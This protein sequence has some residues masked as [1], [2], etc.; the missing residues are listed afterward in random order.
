MSNRETL[1]IIELFRGQT[2]LGLLE[3]ALHDLD[4]EEW[5]RTGEIVGQLPISSESLRKHI[6]PLRSLEVF[7]VRDPD[8]NIPHWKVADS[9]V[10]RLLDEYHESEHP[11]LLE[12]LNNVPTRKLVEFFLTRANPEQ[13]YSRNK[14]QQTTE[15]G[16]HGIKDNI[17]RLA[18]AG[19]VETVE[20]KRSMEYRL[21]PNE[22]IVRFLQ[23]L[24]EALYQAYQR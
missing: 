18:E 13:S 19:I 7:T 4:R 10:I 11:S 12:L 15:A 6:L 8:A 16:F 14:L 17:D 9:E 21:T 23:Q 24:N 22:P 20:G 3:L 1:P 2:R 5:Y